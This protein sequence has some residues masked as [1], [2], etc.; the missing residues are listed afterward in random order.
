MM[1][2]WVAEYSIEQ[3]CFH[4]ETV[5]EMIEENIRCALTKVEPY[6]IPIGIFNEEE[7]AHQFIEK[8]RPKIQGKE[9]ADKF[10]SVTTI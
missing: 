4:V 1:N 10:K 7:Q 6:Y 3:N 9:Y 8:I 5:K 2:Y